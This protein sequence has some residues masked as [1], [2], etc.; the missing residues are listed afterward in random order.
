M[1]SDG[2]ATGGEP[3][4]SESAAAARLLG[5]ALVHSREALGRDHCVRLHERAEAARVGER[6]RRLDLL[7]RQQ[8]LLLRG[9][10]SLVHPVAH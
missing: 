9:L 4:E 2:R 7:A 1:L 5:A 8:R 6:E 10:V 3:L